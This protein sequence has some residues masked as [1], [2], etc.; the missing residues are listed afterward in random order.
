MKVKSFIKILIISIFAYATLNVLLVNNSNAAIQVVPTTSPH[1]SIS[2]NDAF[3]YCYDMRYQSST[4]GN[5]S[6]DPH[7]STARDW[8]AVAYLGL[9]SYG[10]VRAQN[11][12]NIQ[13]ESR[14]HTTTGNISG[15]MN[16][17]HNAALGG[18]QYT[19]VA[20][21]IVERPQNGSVSKLYLNTYNKYVDVLNLP[22]KNI[23]MADGETAGWYSSAA[24]SS[25]WD[26][27]VVLVRMG[28][29]GYTN[30]PTPVT[31]GE[32]NNATTYRPAIW[33]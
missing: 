17:G 31:Y 10:T 23:G 13:I 2:M 8:A 33:N 26:D 25:T 11:G 12:D 21:R 24:S 22:G 29:F 6:L 18:N 16:F 1:R 7:L 4:L 19:Y 15:V 28:T 30:D 27:H 20:N 5:N 32:A 3:Q 14:N 9:S